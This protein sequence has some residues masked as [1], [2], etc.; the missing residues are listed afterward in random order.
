M[1]INNTVVNNPQVSLGLSS[2]I[3][4]MTITKDNFI[5]LALH[6][7][8]SE[9]DQIEI[10]HE[11]EVPHRQDRIGSNTTSEGDSGILLSGGGESAKTT[12]ASNNQNYP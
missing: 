6:L 5:D 7:E 8:N 12:A 10:L 4:V 2:S 3:D 9:N 11:S 1:N